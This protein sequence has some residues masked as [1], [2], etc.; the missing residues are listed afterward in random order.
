MEEG[1]RYYVI[2]HAY[3]HYVGE[4]V[5]V[6]GPKTVELRNVCQVHSCGRN[7]TEFFRGGIGEDTKYDVWPDGLVV[8]A[9]A[10]LPW[11]T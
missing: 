6:I 10:F 3:F 8:S 2:A 5:R 11:A 4:V 9:I 1:K 7:W